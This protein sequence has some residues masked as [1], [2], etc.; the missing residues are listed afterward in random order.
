MKPGISDA[1]IKIT[2]VIGQLLSIVRKN[3]VGFWG[4]SG[5]ANSSKTADDLLSNDNQDKHIN[6]NS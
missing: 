6:K 1:F 4:K 2:K 5:S 3:N